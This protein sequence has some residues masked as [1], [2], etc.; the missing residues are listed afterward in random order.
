MKHPNIVRV[1]NF[2]EDNGSAYMVMEFEQG[3]SLAAL[4]RQKPQLSEDLLLSTLF[5]LLDGLKKL[6]GMGFIHRDIKPGNIYIREDGSPVLLDFGAARQVTGADEQPLT[7]FLTPGYAPFEQYMDS[8]QPQGPWTD[9]YALGAVLYRIISGQTP[10]RATNRGNA[11]LHQRPDPMPT[12]ETMGRGRFSPGFLTSV[13]WA[14]QVLPGDRPQN[15]A[16]WEPGFDRRTAKLA[17]DQSFFQGERDRR[18]RISELE[19]TIIDRELQSREEPPCCERCDVL[20]EVALET[21]PEDGAEVVCPGC[22]KQ[23][24]VLREDYYYKSWFSPCLAAYILHRKRNRM[25]DGIQGEIRLLRQL[26]QFLK[27]T[28]KNFKNAEAT[29]FFNFIKHNPS[30]EGDGRLLDILNQLYGILTLEGLALSNPFENVSQESVAAEGPSEHFPEIQAFIQHLLSNHA[31]KEI[32]DELSYINAL[33]TYLLSNGQTPATIGPEGI[34]LFMEGFSGQDMEARDSNVL[35]SVLND[36]FTMLVSQGYLVT[37][38]VTTL[39]DLLL[40]D[41]AATKIRLKEITERP[42]VAEEPTSVVPSV[43][44]SKK[45]SILPVSPSQQVLPPLPE[46]RGGRANKKWYFIAIV[47]GLAGG[48]FFF[49]GKTALL[50]PPPVLPVVSGGTKIVPEATILKKPPA[51]K[52]V[53]EKNAAMVTVSPKREKNKKIFR[54]VYFRENRLQ[55]YHRQT[56]PQAYTDQPFLADSYHI[57]PMP[58]IMNNINAGKALFNSH[59]LACHPEGERKKMASGVLAPN[60]T[61][62]LLAG[63]GVFERDAYLYW[64]IAEG[65]AGLGT[66]MPTFKKILDEEQIWLVILSFVTL[67]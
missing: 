48:L 54:Q 11:R 64:T 43:P 38:P 60:K 67:D 63:I 36:L 40:R 65:G 30:P 6:H 31:Q 27:A 26:E 14:L 18:K 46:K 34:M 62:L 59:C 39:Y 12:A 1:L 9:I 28:G 44:I 61:D 42:P 56:H 2:F 52:S 17:V 16:A 32:A 22:G 13:D 53:P 23:A 33:E 24:M 10:I 8:G 3:Q 55:N 29:D 47:M 41:D 58:P 21:I 19:K 25:L 5:P 66:E 51:K 15:I 45:S 50:S 4:L 57:N 20:L 37:S 7:A 49:I 35:I